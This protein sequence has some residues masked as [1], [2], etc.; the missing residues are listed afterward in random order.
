[1]ENFAKLEK[2]GESM[3][4]LFAE[5]HFKGEIIDPSYPLSWPP[6]AHLTL[7]TLNNSACYF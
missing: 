3:Y 6:F 7:V 1:M 5:I 2:M 4:A